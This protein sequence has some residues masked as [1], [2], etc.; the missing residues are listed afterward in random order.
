M[1]TSGGGWTLLFNLDSGDG[2][3]HH[4]E[5]TTW[6]QTSSTE[7]SPA[8]TTGHKSAAY[9]TVTGWDE[10]MIRSHN[11]GS[12]TYAYAI[13][14][15]LPAF[16]GQTFLQIVAT[17]T[18]KVFT[19]T[20]T[21]VTGDVPTILNPNRSQT[22]HGDV[23]TEFNDALKANSTSGWTA[24]EN[25]NRLTTTLTNGT[26]SHTFAGLGGRH[27]NGLGDYGTKFE[28]APISAYCDLRNGYGT[29]SNATSF[30]GSYPYSGSCRNAAFT[31][32]PVDTALFVR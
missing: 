13:R 15:L 22:L 28:S 32:I 24:A 9:G 16:A 7:G 14:S 31:W 18:D 12:S 5:D 3:N 4:Y 8:L 6:W 26:Y 11:N 25:V 2:V 19:G 1:T 17:G 10:V 29:D 20:A 27:Q 23:F 30:Q 21:T